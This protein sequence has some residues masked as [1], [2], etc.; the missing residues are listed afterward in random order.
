[1]VVVLPKNSGEWMKE[2]GTDEQMRLS[3]VETEFYKKALVVSEN[4]TK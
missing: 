2:V 4:F 3:P 1:M